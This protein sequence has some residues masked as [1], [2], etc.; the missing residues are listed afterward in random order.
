MCFFGT[1]LS[2]YF[3]FYLCFTQKS[4]QYIKF[5][6]HFPH[7][8]YSSLHLSTVQRPQPHD[9][10]LKGES[11]LFHSPHPV[12]KLVFPTGGALL[13]PIASQLPKVTVS[14]LGGL[15]SLAGLL[16]KLV[17]SLRITAKCLV[18][19][20][21]KTTRS[22]RGSAFRTS[23]EETLVDTLYQKLICQKVCSIPQRGSPNSTN[24]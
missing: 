11:E 8:P 24:M 20:S 16:L 7:V 22:S 14:Q 2:L 6:F 3:Y 1:F 5:Y 4:E 23:T 9:V 18:A 19:V 21:L 12:L 13:S 15:L 10:R 17:C